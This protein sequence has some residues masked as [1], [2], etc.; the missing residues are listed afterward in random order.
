MDDQRDDLFLD[1]L[2]GLRNGD[3]SRLEPLFEGTV[4]PG[5]NQAAIVRWHMQGHFDPHPAE[6]AEALANACF[7]GKVQVAAYLIGRGVDATAGMGTGLNA[8]HWAADR[9]QLEAVRLLLNHGV[10]LEIRNM[11]G[12]TALGSLV[13]SA[14]HT[15]RA[16]HAAIAEA[17]LA[18]GADVTAVSLPTGHADVDEI[19]RRRG[20]CST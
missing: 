18:A 17:L 6:L 19:L 12:G 13:W 2:A 20:A 3:F 4:E 16:D 8:L 15:P 14:S 11:Y 10:P 1:A 7:L 5:D 9:G